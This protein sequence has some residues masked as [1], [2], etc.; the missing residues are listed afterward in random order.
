[1]AERTFPVASLRGRVGSIAL[2]GRVAATDVRV[3]APLVV[4]LGSLALWVL[5]VR[6]AR[7]ASMGLLGLVT[8]L[9]RTYFIGLALAIAALCFELVQPKLREWTV[10]L[11]VGV[12]VVFIFGTAC[13]V[14][15][16]AALSTT[17][18][19]A[20]FIQYIY[21]HGHALNYYDAEFSWPGAFSLGALMISFMGQSNALDL[22][23][24][25]PLAI[26]LSYLVP[27]VVIARRSG[28]T[29]R[30]GWLGIAIFYG[31]DWIYQDY[32]SPQA[33]NLLFFLVVIAAVL[34]VWQPAPLKEPP[35]TGLA[36]RLLASR[37]S[38]SFA[39]L[40]G[41][42]ATTSLEPRKV[43]AILGVL[44]V[45]LLASAMSH[46]LTPYAIFLALVACLLT[47]R[48]GRP[49]LAAV[50]LL[51]AV[52]WLSLGASNF[53]LG[54]LSTIFGSFGQFIGVFNS[55]VS[56]RV[57]GSASHREI[58]DIR[59]LL[60]AA[61]FGLAFIGFL[62]RATDSRMLEVLTVSQ[63]AVLAAQ[64]YGGEGLLRVA[65]LAG[66]FASLLAASA[67]FPARKTAALSP[68]VG[69]RLAWPSW[70]KVRIPWPK[71]RVWVAIC[72]GIALLAFAVATTVVRGGNDAYEA[73]SVGEVDA[74]NYVYAHVKVGQT[75]GLIAP[76]APLGQVD[77]GSV[78]IFVVAGATAIPTVSQVGTILRNQSP[79]Y[80]IL[81]AAQEA[82]GVILAGYPP[83]WEAR[84]QRYLVQRGYAVDASW[85]TAT[86]LRFTATTVAPLPPSSSRAT[87]APA[88]R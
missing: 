77:V 23:R 2:R 20:G 19:H 25:F 24:W 11:L 66:P 8:I 74:A 68:L 16:V 36:R 39:R 84:L 10:A 22:L 81:S 53:W 28:V 34:W 7:F 35:P 79:N 73:Y 51:L 9:P 83:G 55:N 50:A 63:F 64:N 41:S 69:D 31:T 43:V 45:I 54:H 76:Y 87:H 29:R 1:M 3:M 5:A 75:I 37:R 56:S 48:L 62:R 80:V 42:E 26:E 33:L 70:A 32:F 86:V 71:R 4:G 78:K 15:P 17:W 46:Q 65:L 40:R 61:L 72:A 60:T 18:I 21:A 30:A 38:I 44:V 82:W 49:E 6:Q 14:E 52:G 57:T 85:S 59:I 67:I 13:A 12:L 47:R 27:L 58:V 88:R